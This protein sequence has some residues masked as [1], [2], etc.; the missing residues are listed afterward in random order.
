MKYWRRAA[1]IFSVA[2]VLVLGIYVA[3]LAY[4]KFACVPT[5]DTLSDGTIVRHACLYGSTSWRV[6]LFTAGYF[7][8]GVVVICVLS[9]LFLGWPSDVVSNYFGLRRDRR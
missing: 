6:I 8:G 1:L 7:V 3:V 2:W 9:W 4:Q 5:V